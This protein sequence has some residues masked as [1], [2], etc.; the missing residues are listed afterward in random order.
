MQFLMKLRVLEQL[1]KTHRINE[2]ADALN[3]RQPTVT[4]HMQSL[5]KEMHTK[6]FEQRHGYVGLTDAGLAFLHY[7][8]K[9]TGLMNEAQRIMEELDQLKRGTL[10]IGASY[11]PATYVLPD[12]LTRFFDEYPQMQV[13]MHVCPFRSILESLSRHEVDFGVA[14]LTGE[15]SE[16]YV[17]RPIGRDELVVVYS[18]QSSLARS[19]TITPE[20]LS[21]GI[22]IQHGPG[23]STRQFAEKWLQKAGISSCV[24]LE[25]D[26]IETIKRM[27]QQMDAYSVLSR[28]A[29][30]TEVAAGALMAQPLPLEPIYREMSLIFRNDRFLTPAAKKF[31]EFITSRQEADAASGRI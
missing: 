16:E 2:T 3:L 30:H 11:V 25:I 20:I 10:T 15:L 13:R 14:Y 7:A 12:A 23:S 18:P 6:L 21:Q 27:L 31:I 1:G 4:F 5:E 17:C 8:Q 24:K 9:I 26:S 29:V 19:G 22:L 28:L